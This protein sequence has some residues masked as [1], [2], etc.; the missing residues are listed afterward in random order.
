MAMVST[1]WYETL[2]RAIAVLGND[3][4][5][6]GTTDRFIFSVSDAGGVRRPIYVAVG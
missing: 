1:A 5:A 4:E 3:Y 6:L 2:D